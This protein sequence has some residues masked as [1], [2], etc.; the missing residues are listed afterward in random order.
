MVRPGL[1]E[2]Q[3]GN[4]PCR[5]FKE[6]SL[7]APAV[8]VRFFI[9]GYL[10]YLT[11]IVP[12]LLIWSPTEKHDRCLRLNDS[13]TVTQ[14]DFPSLTAQHFG[15]FLVEMLPSW[16]SPYR[17]Q[18]TDPNTSRIKDV[19]GALLNITQVRVGPKPKAPVV[20]G[21]WLCRGRLRASDC[22]SPVHSIEPWRVRFL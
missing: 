8:L 5:K 9:F 17:T 10:N 7:H 1:P 2:V 19:L 21:I 16:L 4:K 6:M 20:R 18:T 14:I 11:L 22:F 12:K 3:I 13:L 15:G